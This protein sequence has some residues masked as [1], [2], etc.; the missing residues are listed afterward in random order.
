M[1]AKNKKRILV[2]II[3][4]LLLIN[5]SAITTIGYNRYERNKTID[6]EYIRDDNEKTHPHNR[7]KLFV[8]RELELSDNQFEEYCKMKDRNLQRTEKYIV[9][10]KKF[11]KE[12]IAEINKEE[13]DSMLLLN[14]SDSIGKQ[15]KLINIEM[16]RHFLAIKQIL[17]PEQQKKLNELLERIEERDGSRGNRKFKE[18]EKGH[19]YRY[20]G[21]KNK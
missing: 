15:H 14:L 4:L 3:I 6:K 20:R 18:S 12:I 19:K 10:I 2:G 8:K 13:P 7:M 1:E 17:N 5:L 11:K 9:K 21:E 16:N